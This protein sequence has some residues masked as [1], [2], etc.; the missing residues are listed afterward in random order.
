MAEERPS[1]VTCPKCHEGDIGLV[2]PTDF[3][4]QVLGVHPESGR[5][6]V[7][8]AWADVD[9]IHPG[10]WMSLQGQKPFFA[11]ELRVPLKREKPPTFMCLSCGDSWSVPDW[12]KIGGIKEP[13]GIG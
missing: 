4:Y 9:F 2:W 7:E 12:M 6:L 13:E 1:K 8:Y 3:N 11:R 10:V 5:V